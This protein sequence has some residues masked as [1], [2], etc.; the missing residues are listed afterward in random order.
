VNGDKF[1]KASMLHDV[2]KGVDIGFLV[3]RGSLSLDGKVQ[4][5]VVLRSQLFLRRKESSVFILEVSVALRL[6]ECRVFLLLLYQLVFRELSG[7]N[8]LKVATKCDILFLL[9]DID[10]FVEFF[11]CKIE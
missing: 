9:S 10:L 3:Q 6:I 11:Q 5:V 8:P 4:Q 2:G 7:S 1:Y